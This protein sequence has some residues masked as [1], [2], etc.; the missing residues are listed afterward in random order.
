M[1]ERLRV[2]V[3]DDHPLVLEGL[4]AVLTAEPDIEVVGAAGTAEEGVAVAA[5]ERPEVVVTDF[6]LPG[7]TGAEAAVDLRAAVP[8][9]AIVFLSADDSDASMMAAVEAG[10]AAYLAKAGRPEALVEAVRRAA[11]GEMLIPA[12]VLARLIG[13]RSAQARAQAGR[14]AVERAFTAREREI[15][16]LMSLGLDNPSI[17]VRLFIE[18]TTVRWHVRNLIEKLG[19][20]SKLEA[21]ARAAEHGLLRR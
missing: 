14:E 8:G 12:A 18:P 4:L 9:V 19:A 13:V 16:D 6:R 20:H 17:A 2:V 11:A 1:E 15:L 5:R 3:I 21:V 7:R 10:A